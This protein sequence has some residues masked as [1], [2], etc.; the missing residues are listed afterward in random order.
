[1]CWHFRWYLI[2][3]AACL[4]G[5]TSGQLAELTQVVTGAQTL[6]PGVKNIMSGILAVDG[7]HQKCMQRTLC[8]A[9]AG[10]LVENKIDFD[11]VKRSVVVVP[12]VIREE[13]KLR[14]IGD[15]I[16]NLFKR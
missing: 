5:T 2:P 9:F 10:K 8:H 14:W 15:L 4:L 1:M 13:G 6:I 11:P 12:K 16:V 7:V 3:F